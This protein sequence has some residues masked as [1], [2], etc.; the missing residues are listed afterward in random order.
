MIK[1]LIQNKLKS[2]FALGVIALLVAFLLSGGSEFLSLGFIK[3]K[4][5]E[6]E[7]WYQANPVLMIA[8]FFLL[9][10][11]V[12]GLSIPGAVF[13]TLLAGAIFGLWWGTLIVSFASSLG[14]TLAFI[15]SR[16]VLSDW[17]QHRFPA[18]IEVI[19][20][21]LT[22]QGSLYLLTL[23][24]LPIVPFFVVNLVMGLTNF[25]VFR[26]YWVSQLGMLALTLVYVNVGT[27][28]ARIDHLEGI[29]SPQL[30]LALILVATLPFLSKRLMLW[31]RKNK[32]RKNKR[33][34]GDEILETEK[35]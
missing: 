23:R 19:N 9:Y 33:K 25:N 6:L 11:C 20:K 14:A 32:T 21:G 30:W 26:F 12:T 7:A 34:A 2:F 3:S 10:V 1:A 29:L 8:G 4:Q 35:V 27:E 16:W 24:M 22:E 31:V 5:L 13:L 18:Q 28:L 17:V 15:M